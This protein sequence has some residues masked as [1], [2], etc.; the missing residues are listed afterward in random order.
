MSGKFAGELN[1]HRKKVFRGFQVPA[2]R[3]GGYLRR[4]V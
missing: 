2:A 3:R 1:V 4:R